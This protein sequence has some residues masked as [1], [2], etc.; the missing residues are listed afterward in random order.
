MLSMLV[1]LTIVSGRNRCFNLNFLGISIGIFF[2]KTRLFKF[3]QALRHHYLIA[4]L[5]LVLCLCMQ[6]SFE[7]RILNLRRQYTCTQFLLLSVS[8]FCLPL[9][10][11]HRYDLVT[12]S[13]SRHLD[14]ARLRKHLNHSVIVTCGCFVQ[15]DTLAGCLCRHLH[16]YCIILAS[17]IFGIFCHDYAFRGIRRF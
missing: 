10:V 7:I 2:A 5:W 13:G 17:L 11:M 16:L 1:I 4:S 6:H 12:I 8:L 14:L 9:L 3:F 15:I